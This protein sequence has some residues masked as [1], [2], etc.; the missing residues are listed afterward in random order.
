MH[1]PL[2]ELEPGTRR[3]G[4]GEEEEDGAGLTQAT[5]AVAS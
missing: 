3:R 1:S 5:N 2:C 4:G